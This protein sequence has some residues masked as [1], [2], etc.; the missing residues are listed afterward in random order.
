[1]NPL[2][3]D[4]Q[5][6]TGALDLTQLTNLP[7]VSISTSFGESRSA[8]SL[9]PR[10]TQILSPTSAGHLKTVM[11]PEEEER[12][13][14]AGCLTAPATW[15]EVMEC[16]RAAFRNGDRASL[17]HLKGDVAGCYITTS[18]VFLFKSQTSN[19]TVF[20]RRFGTW[21]WWSTDPS[22]LA[23]ASDLDDDALYECC[24]GE[25]V[26]V[27]RHQAFVRA[28]TVLSLRLE[29]ENQEAFAPIT[30]V[31]LSPLTSF[32]EAAAMT[33]D[34]LLEATAPLAQSGERIRLIIVLTHFSS[35]IVPLLF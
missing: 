29:Q 24:A 2:I 31:V 27:Y 16:C 8:S 4:F 23:E 20:Y 12:L 7:A 6:F 17:I 3:F 13:L 19:D 21:L 34:A 10:L 22:D 30:A 28:G 32:Q 15:A 18:G 11:L 9:T 26:F 35:A 1:M 5:G 25:D 14:H 33:Q